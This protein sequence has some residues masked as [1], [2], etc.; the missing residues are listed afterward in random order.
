MYKIHTIKFVREQ[1]LV[2]GLELISTVYK[3]NKQLLNYKCKKCGYVGTKRYNDLQQGYGCPKCAN[4][5]KYNI[6]FV[7]MTFLERNMELIT[8]NYINNRQRLSYKC[9]KCGYVGKK[10]FDSLLNGQQ[11]CPEC[12]RLSMLGDGNLRY[13]KARSKE[14]RDKISKNLKGRYLGKKH[15]NWNPELSNEDRVKGRDYLEYDEWRF[16]IYNRDNHK[17]QVCGKLGKVAHH[18]ESYS[19]NPDLRIAL[20]NGVCLCEKCHKEFHSMYGY[21]NNTRKQFIEFIN[22]YNRQGKLANV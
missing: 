1:F 2:N 12:H 18:L 16:A 13:G 8:K 21:G 15:P 14:V 20:D 10:V 17:C 22:N 6:E 19:S 9:L 3:S 4:N 5:I 11:G 7:R